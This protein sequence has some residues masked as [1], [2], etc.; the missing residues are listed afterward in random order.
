MNRVRLLDC[1]LRDGGYMN[2]WKFG[3]KNIRYIIDHCS[4]AG[5]D[6]IECGFLSDVKY[7]KGYSIFPD[8]KTTNEFIPDKKDNRLYVA[9][10]AIGEKEIHPDKLS[11]AKESKIKGI[12]LTFHPEETKKAFNWAKLLMKKGYKVFMQPVGSAN[13]DDETLLRLIGKINQLRPYAFYLVDTLGTM[14]Q[15]DISRILYLVD[16]N[17]APD[18]HLGF[19]SHNNLQM[20]FANAQ[21]LIHF[22]TK[23]KM[24][25]DCCIY[26]MGRGAGNLCTELLADYLNQ[27][28]MK[29]YQVIPILECIDE[30]IMY[31]FAKFP[32]GYSAAYFLASSKKCHPNYASYLLS[33]QKLSAYSISNLLDQLSETERL[34]FHKEAIT[35]LYQKYQ[36]HAV[37][38]RVDREWQAEKVKGKKVLIIGTGTTIRSHEKR[39]RHYIEKHH[40]FVISVN[41]VENRYETNL[42]FIGNEK[43]YHH[44]EKELDLTK[45][46]FSSN[47]ENLPENAHIVN[48]ADL[49]NSS[50]DV[51]DNAGLM[52]IKLLQQLGVKDIALA[53]MDGYRGNQIL[54]YA[55]KKMIGSVE[56]LETRVKNEETSEQ[57]SQMAKKTKIIFVTPSKYK[58]KRKEKF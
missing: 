24:I 6:I 42:V 4:K 38:D 21:E 52:V 58:L 53:G 36:V 34:T 48:Y 16:N 29:Q 32:W 2:N 1:T 55:D 56:P 44:Y 46:I 35:D 9:M 30:C 20:S 10:I 3:E 37:D 12:R 43:R 26:G 41:F 39:I 7:V 57:L 17:L 51:S 25:I 54:N 45:T 31:Y 13:Y 8:T 50:V 15:K 23:R 19:H 18:I 5:I 22:S 47:I 40:P 28:G 14:Y 11:F 27:T 49:I 33:K